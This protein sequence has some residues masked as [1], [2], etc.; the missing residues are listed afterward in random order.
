MLPK[1]R[2][3]GASKSGTKD[4]AS[5]DT[6]QWHDYILMIMNNKIKIVL[7]PIENVFGP[8]QTQNYYSRNRLKGILVLWLLVGYWW[9]EVQNWWDSSHFMPS[10]TPTDRFILNRNL[11]FICQLFGNWQGESVKKQKRKFTIEYSLYHSQMIMFYQLR[12]LIMYN[13]C[14]WTDWFKKD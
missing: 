7:K 12:K 8:G 11:A 10:Q 3:W 6:I 2:F 4:T 5:H 14:N 13:V 1:P 9:D